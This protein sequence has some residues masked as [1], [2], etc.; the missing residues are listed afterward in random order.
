M[1]SQA[2]RR[3]SNILNLAHNNLPHLGPLLTLSP[4]TVSL[5]L[6]FNH[7]HLSTM[8]SLLLQ[9]SE[10]VIP[11]ALHNLLPFFA[12]ITPQS[13]SSHFKCYLSQ[14]DLFCFLTLN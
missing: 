13:S 4:T 1:V 3:K 6:N 8:S 5:S 2:F 7:W 12:W 9:A 11:S 10:H 14:R